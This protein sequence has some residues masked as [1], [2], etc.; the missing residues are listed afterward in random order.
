MWSSVKFAGRYGIALYIHFC[1]EYVR[2]AVCQWDLLKYAL[3]QLKLH[4]H[5][6]SIC[7]KRQDT[8]GY[9]EIISNHL[10]F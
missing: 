3:E 6:L 4:V 9:E 2:N 5:L 8:H 10:D 7:Y 1:L